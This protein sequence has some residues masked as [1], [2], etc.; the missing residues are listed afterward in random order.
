MELSPEQHLVEAHK[1]IEVMRQSA[2]NLVTPEGR[3]LLKVHPTHTLHKN[4]P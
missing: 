1:E 2:A 4:K 3:A